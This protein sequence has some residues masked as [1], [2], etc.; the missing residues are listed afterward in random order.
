MTSNLFRRIATL[1]AAAVLTLAPRFAAAQDGGSV[2]LA[3]GVV[4]VGGFP[5]SF[6]A[7]RLSGTG[8]R[9]GFDLDAGLLDYGYGIPDR[10]VAGQ[11][12]FLPR[13]RS[14]KGTAK[15][16]LIGFS[17]LDTDGLTG[18][19]GVGH[20]WLGRRWRVGFDMVMSGHGIFGKL[21]VGWGGR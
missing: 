11:L 15:S 4:G 7:V 12:R 1:G 2:H 6:T 10:L 9:I 8:S 16:Y 14:D 21:F 18:Q 19:F 13:R 17:S 20:D 5:G 3:V